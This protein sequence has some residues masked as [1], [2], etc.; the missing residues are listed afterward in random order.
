MKAMLVTVPEAAVLLGVSKQTVWTWVYR[1][2]IG[3]VKIGKSRRIR[4]SEIER[5]V[6]ASEIPARQ[7][8]GE[9]AGNQ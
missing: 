5:F 7:A 3:S 1:R 2:E 6:S 4:V 9:N 8:D